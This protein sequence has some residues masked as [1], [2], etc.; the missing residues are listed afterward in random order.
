M[1]RG[2]RI[3]AAAAAVACAP[4]HA[5]SEADRAR[6]ASLPL[7]V[8]WDD[9]QRSVHCLTAAIYYEAGNEP[10]DGQRAVAQVIF[11][12]VTHAAWP[13]SVCD[14]VFQGASRRTGCQFTFTCDGSLLRPPVEARWRAAEAV[15][16]EAIRAGLPD[17]VGAATHYHAYY[18]NPYWSQ[19]LTRLARI[20]AHI[21]YA[22]GRGALPGGYVQASARTA[23]PAAAAPAPGT[24]SV[25]GLP[26]AVVK[27]R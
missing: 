11:N 10:L 24:F 16:T 20:G 21:F 17:V 19:S 4:A 9:A 3:L 8:G 5:T 12:R 22:A 13:D 25:W 6:M 15:A 18:V 23:S 27:P 26:V 1:L 2:M 14:V 7:D